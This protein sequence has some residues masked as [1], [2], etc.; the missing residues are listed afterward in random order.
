MPALNV[1][2]LQFDTLI[3]YL[4]TEGPVKDGANM[5]YLARLSTRNGVYEPRDN[6]IS[7]LKS[8]G[9][10]RLIQNQDIING[11]MDFERSIAQ[12][13]NLLD[14]EAKENMLSYPLLGTLFDARVF[15]KMVVVQN[16]RLTEKEYASGS[17][18]N[19]LMPPDNPQLIS[20]DKEKIN[21]LIYYLHQRKSSFMGEMRRLSVQ[22]AVVEKLIETI[23]REYHLKDE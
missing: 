8:S 12:Y 7:E 21:L 4:Q 10:L 20:H 14:I 22:R 18:N 2:V 6:T 9:N 11:M 19:T 13:T 3:N 15:D 1:R 16:N 17:T 5:Y 23:N